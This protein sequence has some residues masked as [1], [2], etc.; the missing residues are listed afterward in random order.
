MAHKKM[1]KKGKRTYK[2]DFLFIP[3]PGTSFYRLG[4][5]GG[6]ELPLELSG[7]FTGKREAQK[8]IDNYKIFKGID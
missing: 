3:V 1:I 2:K 6:G 4:F 8:A 5:D 7:R